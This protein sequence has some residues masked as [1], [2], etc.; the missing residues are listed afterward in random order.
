MIAC[1]MSAD[2]GSSSSTASWTFRMR[3]TDWPAL[4]SIPDPAKLRI[5][6][7]SESD[8]NPAFST[9]FNRA[10]KKLGGEPIRLDGTSVMIEEVAFEQRDVAIDGGKLAK[11]P[12]A[13]RK[14][15]V[16]RVDYSKTLRDPDATGPPVT[17][18]LLVECGGEE[19]HYFSAAKKY[20]AV[21]W[22]LKN[23]DKERYGFNAIFLDKL[24]KSQEPIMLQIRG[25]NR[26]LIQQEKLGD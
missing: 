15:L 3:A 12:T 23:D 19:H 9:E 5:W 26:F 22:D 1:R 2:V 13:P 17:I 24:K 18:Q 4:Q 10:L 20:T 16:V 7:S 6:A 11:Y 21:F 14:C 25:Q 8:T